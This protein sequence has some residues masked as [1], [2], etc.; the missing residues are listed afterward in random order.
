MVIENRTAFS[1]A[2]SQRLGQIVGEIGT[3]RFCYH[4]NAGVRADVNS[5]PKLAKRVP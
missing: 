4:L 5:R 2:K 1:P 3:Y